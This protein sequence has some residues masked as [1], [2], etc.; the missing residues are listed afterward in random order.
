[1][2]NENPDL[3]QEFPEFKDRIHQLKTGDAHFKKLFDEY[4]GVNAEIK[5]AEQE[6]E[7]LGDVAMET[8]RKKRLLLKDQL[9]ALRVDRGSC[10][11][12]NHQGGI[13]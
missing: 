2:F 6:I 10:F 12:Q 8:L 3:A 13:S 1:M 5:R 11:I 9:F 4:H 7:T